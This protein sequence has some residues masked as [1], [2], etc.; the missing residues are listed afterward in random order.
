MQK[1]ILYKGQ[2][3]VPPDGMAPDGDLA[4]SVNMLNE[5]GALRPLVPPM[6][7]FQVNGG[8][9]VYI[10]KAGSFTHYIFLSDQND[11]YWAD[12]SSI[13]D[14]STVTVTD[15]SPV[16]TNTLSETPSRFYVM[17]NTLLVFCADGM[18]YYLWKGGST[19]YYYLGN[20]IPECP[21]AFTTLADMEASE[22]LTLFSLDD[23]DSFRISFDS[24]TNTAEY[25]R[26]LSDAEAEVVTEKTLASV[27]KF[28]AEK[29]T[30]AGKFIFPFYVRYAYRLYDGETLCMH[31]AP[32]FMVCSSGIAPVVMLQATNVS[33]RGNDAY[34]TIVANV[35]AL[36]HK[37]IYK[38]ISSQAVD[39]LKDW[40][41]IVKSID[42]FVSSPI[43]SYDYSGECSEFVTTE[44]CE[45]YSLC[46]ISPMGRGTQYE[47]YSKK[48]MFLDYF[49]LS[50]ISLIGTGTYHDKY[51]FCVGLP[52]KDNFEKEIENRSLFYF[53]K[54]IPLDDLATADFEQIEIK[55]DYLQSLTSRELMTDDYDSHDYLLPTTAY[56][57]NARLNL[58]GMKKTLFDGYNPAAAFH[59]TN[60]EDSDLLIASIHY[61]I[62]RDGKDIVVK[63][64]DAELRKQSPFVNIFYPDINAKK[65]YLSV[66]NKTGIS[67]INVL[68][69][70]LKPHSGLN[71]AYYYGGFGDIE[72][73][74]SAIEI[75]AVTTGEDRIVHL[76]NKIYSSQVNNPFYFPVAGIKT[77]GTE[78]ILALSAA[79][80]AMSQGQFGQFPLYIFTEGGVWAQDINSDGSFGG[81]SIATRDVCSSPDTI[82][83]TDTAVL[84]ASARGIML[85]DGSQG[86]CITDE[87]NGNLGEI[88]EHN[89]LLLNNLF[90]MAGLYSMSP[91]QTGHTLPRFTDFLADSVM[92][93]DYVHQRLYVCNETY[94]FSYVYSM[95]SGLWG[96][97]SLV[98]DA[99]LNSF[100]DTLVSD[101]DSS[102]LSLSDRPIKANAN[103]LLLT[104]PLS[105]DH[106]NVFKTVNE[107]RQRGRL[108]T[109][110]SALLASNDMLRWAV[111]AASS[112][113]R[114]PNVCGTP[115]KYFR[116]AVFDNVFADEWLASAT[117]ELTPKLTNRMR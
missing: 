19:G 64:E 80:K 15:L 51:K 91:S 16:G 104:R 96:M 23:G 18:H 10:H 36:T 4:L 27:N 30:E 62:N 79:T 111:V 72:Y 66:H 77:Y 49:T 12:K 34:A 37:L 9:C 5:K 43:Y 61:V 6:Q 103:F 52:V 26:R 106:Y 21:L 101:P 53:L 102:I 31:S 81:R 59:Y 54:S 25:D 14:G 3:A 35:Y 39:R 83:Q 67:V 68:R 69:V 42:I 100:P 107:C 20:H 74:A 117:M 70:D 89:T 40:K 41:D 58:A 85:L 73:N 115:F 93:Y 32:I 82:T 99:A 84:F 71:G 109:A 94:K 98:Y 11:L 86:V 29:S 33:V 8:R 38:A 2:T 65:A 110:K 63:G 28:I 105:L 47:S 87:I 97:S 55:E 95:Q 75:P 76:G 92:A 13:S 45:T 17:G 112:T 1:E 50:G 116:L 114:I 113:C 48:N 78:N 88:L 24:D 56:E 46:R 7:K 108:R 22:Q 57:Y 44:S 60:G 90:N